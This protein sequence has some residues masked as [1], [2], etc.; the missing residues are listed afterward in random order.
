M[1][2]DRPSRQLHAVEPVLHVAVVAAHM[3]LAEAVLHHAGRAQQHLVQRRVLALRDVLDGALAEIVGRGAEARLDGTARLVE[4]RRRDGD[5]ERRIG[6]R[7]LRSAAI[8]DRRHGRDH[9]PCRGQCAPAATAALDPPKELVL[10]DFAPPPPDALGA[11]PFLPAATATATGKA[12]ASRAASCAGQTGTEA[13]RAGGVCGCGTCGDARCIGYGRAGM[14]RPARDLAH[15]QSA[16]SGRGAPRS[17]EGE[18]TVR[19]TVASNGRVSEVALAKSSG[20][21]SLDAAAL[22]LLQ[23]AT[24]PAPGIEATRT[25]RIRFRLND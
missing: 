16:L 23:G 19:F 20:F 22:R 13:R 25:V 2:S 9:G 8:D 14:E 24:L 10:P 7:R 11:A 4:P 15:R 5:A 12:C 6:E 21:A 18:V 1:N 3:D 17:E